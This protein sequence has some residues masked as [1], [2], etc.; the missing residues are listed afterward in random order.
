MKAS[1]TRGFLPRLRRKLTRGRD[2]GPSTDDALVRAMCHDM[3]GSLTCLE[4]AL[5]QLDVAGP[6][7]V[8]LLS[9]ARAQAAHLASML[10]TADAARTASGQDPPAGRPLRDV[11]ATS[12]AAS[13]LP[14]RQL[15]LHVADCA[16]D[17]LVGDARLQR[18]LVNLLE[19][20]HRHGCGEPV[21]LAVT[22]HGGWVEL[23]VTQPGVAAAVVA[24]HL[25]TARPPADLTGLGLWSVQRQ[26][27]ELGGRVVCEDADGALTL[28][29]QVPDR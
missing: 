11:V 13:G 22:C 4:S 29:V 17:V 6:S 14:R 12:L 20:A 28:R 7:R 10:R 3:R 24:G 9:M 23:A 15:T 5:H 1:L 26:A 8:D 18:I 27:H 25:T 21:E 2:A 19:N 16:G